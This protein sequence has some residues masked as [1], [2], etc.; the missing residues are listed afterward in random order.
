M[1]E[2]TNSEPVRIEKIKKII[3]NILGF[4]NNMITS[5]PANAIAI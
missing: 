3:K 2:I 5:T 1:L 4:R